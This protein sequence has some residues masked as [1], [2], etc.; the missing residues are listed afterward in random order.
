[1][2]CTEI[3]RQNLSHYKNKHWQVPYHKTFGKQKSYNYCMKPE[4]KLGITKEF[5]CNYLPEQNER[6]LIAVDERLH[7]PAHYNWL[8]HHGFR[9][10]GDQIYRPHCVN[11]NQCQSIRVVVDKFKPTTSQRVT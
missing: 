1:M 10:S 4:F 3:S 5:P 6:L 9:R 8:M 2:G 7:N 11:C